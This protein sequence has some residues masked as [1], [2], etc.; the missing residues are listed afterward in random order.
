MKKKL[1]YCLFLYAIGFTLFS[2]QY[3]VAQ[4]YTL[5]VLVVDVRVPGDTVRALLWK[6]D[7]GFPRQKE[8]C[9]QRES[10]KANTD[11]AVIIFKDLESGDYAV[12]CF[13]DENNNRQYDR[14]FW[15]QT[16]EPFGLSGKPDYYHL[17]VDYKDARFFLY[18]TNQQIVIKL[19][20]K[21]DA[22]QLLHR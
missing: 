6:G 15:H 13:Y 5:K 21:E 3:S 17:P 11:T 2:P 8:F 1:R 22:H 18:D 14:S 20:Y 19:H 4:I 16:A 12:S 9:L 7:K 10:V